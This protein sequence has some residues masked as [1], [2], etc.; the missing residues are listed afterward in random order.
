MTES[1]FQA[2]EAVGALVVVLEPDG[3]IVHWNRRCSD[4]T[5]YSLEE[6]RG[7]R[8][9]DFALVPE[10]IEPIKAIFAT[11]QPDAQPSPYAN[12]WVTKTGERRWIA[13]SHTTTKASD[14]GVQ[15]RGPVRDSR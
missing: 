5:G 8:L 10:D 2:F 12:Y 9:W 4:L 13:W 6:I 3:R 1:D 15:M 7:R 14:G 11:L